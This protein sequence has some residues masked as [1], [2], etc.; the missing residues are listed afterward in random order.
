MSRATA[1]A[2][3]F[4]IGWASYRQ[5]GRPG[6]RHGKHEY[7][8]VGGHPIQAG[9]SAS[10]VTHAAAITGRYYQPPLASLLARPAVLSAN[11]REDS[12]RPEPAAA[13]TCSRQP[14]DSRLR[15]QP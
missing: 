8:T 4:L 14:S 7:G 10:R 3:S 12:A 15:E 2:R 11:M 9:I 1:H 13:L 5:N 6:R